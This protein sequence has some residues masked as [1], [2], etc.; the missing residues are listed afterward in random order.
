VLKSRR[1]VRFRGTLSISR[2]QR[3]VVLIV[4]LDRP[5][6]SNIKHLSHAFIEIRQSWADLSFEKGQ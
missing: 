4:A 5:L 6:R 2:Q 1:G 3:D